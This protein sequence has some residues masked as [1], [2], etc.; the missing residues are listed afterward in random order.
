LLWAA[1][2]FHLQLLV[3]PAAAALN[4]DFTF[5]E[6]EGKAREAFKMFIS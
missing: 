4:P 6:L 5:T 3:L 1:P 2:S